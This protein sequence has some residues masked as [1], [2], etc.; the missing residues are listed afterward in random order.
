MSNTKEFF[1]G[2]VSTTEQN[3]ERQ[4]A[5]AQEL[6]ISERDIYIDKQSGKDFNRPQ[7]QAVKVQLRQGDTMFVKEL[8]RLGRNADEIKREWAEI[9]QGIGAH[10]VIVDMPILD[11]RQYKNG[12]EKVI[13][14]IVLELLSYMAERER[15]TIR[16]RQAEGIALAKADGK[17]LGRPKME[18]SN[19]FQRVVT[20][21][22]DGNMTA[23]E[24]QRRLNM[25]PATFYRKVRELEIG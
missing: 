12:M 22:Q 5:V 19:E 15:E 4:L 10:I 3:E 9:T 17:H 11:T 24:A 16:K 21:W 18:V 7:Y 14:N 6:G 1:Y 23:R 8:D 20:E 13:S 25:K 2:R